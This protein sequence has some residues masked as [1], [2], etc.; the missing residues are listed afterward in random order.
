MARALRRDT[1][2]TD[3]IKPLGGG[4]QVWRWKSMSSF[5][6]LIIHEYGEL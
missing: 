3:M 2:I 5:T 4:K 6:T 1:E